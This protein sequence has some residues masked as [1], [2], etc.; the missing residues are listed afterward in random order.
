MRGTILGFRDV[1]GAILSDD[2]RRFAFS[3]SNWRDETPPE[4]GLVVDFVERDRTADEIYL[5]LDAAAPS[6]L[7][8]APSPA[9]AAPPQA[10]AADWQEPAPFPS[11]GPSF[12]L[13][14]RPGV[15]IAAAA[16]LLGCFLPFISVQSMPWNV[17]TLPGIVSPAGMAP[18]DGGTV[19]II[20]LLLCSFYAIPVMATMVIVQE[21]RG[22]AGSEL[23]LSAGIVGLMP[24]IFLILILLFVRVNNYLPAGTDIARGTFHPAY[25]IPV[26]ISV[27]GVGWILISIASIALIAVERGWSL[28][29]GHDIQSATG[30]E[31][32]WLLETRPHSIV[33][34]EVFAYSAVAIMVLSSIIISNNASYD[35]TNSSNAVGSWFVEILVYLYIISVIFFTSKRAS[36][37]NK[38]IYQVFFIWFSY[39]SV[40]LL[41][42]ET[43]SM[44]GS[45]SGLSMLLDTIEIGLAIASLY[46][47]FQKDSRNWFLGD[48][49]DSAQEEPG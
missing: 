46:Y 3:I 13:A 9:T 14:G 38:C 7:A 8:V 42:I 21:L 23:R 17:F 26:A 37:I 4:R 12:S 31:I 1:E 36:L 25:F 10:S 11:P 20:R 49:Q 28:L 22:Q 30:A 24:A 29:P 44:H 47:I 5:S 48:G 16:I 43:L 33:F 45:R 35:V 18:Y 27:M 15:I 6:A 34:F 39:S 2:G 41:L 40:L 32:D 19:G